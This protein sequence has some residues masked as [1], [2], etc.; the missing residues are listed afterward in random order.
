[1]RL[2]NCRKWKKTRY[3]IY[4]VQFSGTSGWDDFEQK[5]DDLLSYKLLILANVLR[6]TFSA[7][8]VTLISHKCIYNLLKNQVSWRCLN[9]KDLEWY[10]PSRAGVLHA[11]KFM[12]LS[13]TLF[14]PKTSFIKFSF[15]LLYCYYYRTSTGEI[16]KIYCI[17]GGGGGYF[18]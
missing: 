7:F 12:Q 3:F 5:F 11:C 10:S 6:Y 14:F 13:S 17:S 18:V 1:M 4:F 8:L 2:L 9:E 15:S 16:S